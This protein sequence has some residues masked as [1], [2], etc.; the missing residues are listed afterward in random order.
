M[1]TFF[2]Q[3]RT[4][5]NVA[6]AGEL[7]WGVPQLTPQP[8]PS[9]RQSSSPVAATVDAAD[10]GLEPATPNAPSD[11]NRSTRTA[12]PLPR[13]TRRAWNVRPDWP[14]DNMGPAYRAR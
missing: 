3:C 12:T 1:M 13:R 7:S 9:T 4:G 14:L 8:A 11:E 10:C 6:A 5:E 2:V